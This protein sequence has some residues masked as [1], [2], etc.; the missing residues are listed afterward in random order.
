M[1]REQKEEE[2]QGEEEEEKIHKFNSSSYAKYPM[3]VV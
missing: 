3:G 2:G 1:E